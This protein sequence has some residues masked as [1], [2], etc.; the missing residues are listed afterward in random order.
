M[1][2]FDQHSAGVGAVRCAA[3]IAALLDEVFGVPT[4]PLAVHAP[5]VLVPIGALAAVVLAV[6]PGWR[7]RA[8]WGAPAA[9]FVLALMLFV[10]KESGEAA[11][12]VEPTIV[13]GD[14]TE[15]R[16]LADTTFILGLVWFVV[17]LGLAVWEW[18]SRRESARSLSSAGAL[19]ERDP[20]ATTLAVLSALAAVLT[21]IWLVRTGHAGAAERWPN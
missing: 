16:E 15:H 8:G 4:H 9:V 3:M 12:S 17:A 14:I 2:R 7:R 18:R 1:W 10:A 6:R 19:R 21:A 11:A 13:F 5:V 20:V